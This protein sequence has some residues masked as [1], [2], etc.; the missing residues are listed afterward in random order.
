M[1]EVEFSN[2]YEKKN[3][4]RREIE[5]VGIRSCAGVMVVCRCG[6]EG[7]R[8]ITQRQIELWCEHLQTGRTCR[9]GVG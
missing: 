8:R 4:Y 1:W 6:T 9:K 3:S 2:V 5:N 7:G